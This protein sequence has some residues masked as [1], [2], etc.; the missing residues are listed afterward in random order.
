MTRS[1]PIQR[2]LSSGE[3][4]PLLYGRTDYQRHQT[5]AKAMRGFLPL[6]QGGAT[7]APGTL[8]QG[9]TRNDAQTRVIPFEFQP[10]DAVVLEFSANVMRVRRY[11]VL[12]MDGGSPYELAIPYGLAAVKRLKYVQTADV[13]Y[14]VDGE[15]P[16]QKLSRVAL[17]DWSIEDAEFTG[18]PLRPWNTDEA[19]TVSASGQNGLITLT[20]S[21]GNIWQA[22]HVGSLFALQVFD[23]LDVP[24][25]TGNTP[26][27]VGDRMRFDGRVY[28]CVDATGGNTGANPPIHRSG[29]AL[30]NKDGIVWRH[31]STD[32]GLVRITGYTSGAE[33]QA[34]VID[35]IP[36][37]LIAGTGSTHVWADAAWSDVYGHPA[38]IAEHDQRLFFAATAAEPRTVWGSAIGLYTDF[39]AGTDADLAFAYTIAAKRGLSKILWLEGGGDSLAIGAQAEIQTSH[40]AVRDEAITIE[41]A[42]F[43]AVATMGAFDTAAISPD[44]RP[45]FISRDQKRVF[46]LR[47]ALSDDRV[48]PVELS[49]AAEHLGAGRFTEL[50]WQWAPF[51]L[52]WA[53]RE[54]GL[55]IAFAYDPQEEILGWA[56]VPVGGDVESLAVTSGP[57]GGDDQV[58]VVVKRTIEGETRRHVEQFCPIFGVEPGQND[59][60]LA[61]HLYCAFAD[62]AASPKATW[63]GLDHLEGETV[64]VMTDK[65]EAGPFVV[66]DGAVELTVPVSRVFVGLEATSQRLRTLGVYAATREGD[67]LGRPIG[68]KGVGVRLH[69][70]GGY[71]GRA[72]LSAWGR[73][74]A[75]GRWLERRPG[76]AGG[77]LTRGYSGVDLLEVHAGQG[78]EVDIQLRP[79]GAQPLTLL[80][81]VPHIE[82]HT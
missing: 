32:T 76:D 27:A 2:S 16:V 17:D 28:E 34:Q 23:W 21:G 33:V 53:L 41:N 64:L 81:L 54:D 68:V 19:I 42:R 8:N 25:W 20:A 70:T 56:P 4:S 26:I 55:L 61:Q 10:D 6:R 51:R 71:R 69:Q 31:L 65:G 46:E 78:L 18:G 37:Q 59:I 1:S 58:T 73:P 50:H 72:I 12:V 80:A 66:S 24:L 38:A 74:E 67:A 3:V 48:A 82:A 15:R 79:L 45:I 44:G 43:R 75:P 49:L 13:I 14:L 40:S 77:D 57:Y 52:G 63:S 35:R 7:R 36:V 60:T 39:A 30:A 47:Y 5:G 22:G 9:R 62:K 29:R 11:G